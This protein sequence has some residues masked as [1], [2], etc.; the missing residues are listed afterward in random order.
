MLLKGKHVFIVEDDPQNRVV[1]QMALI[2][3]GA[4]VDFERWGKD[5]LK[6]LIGIGPVDVIILDLMLYNG[7]S[8]YDVF[9]EIREVEQ[10]KSVPIIAVS[11]IDPSVA[12]PE[13]RRRGFSGFIAKPI[14]IDM[15][16]AQIA[17]VLTGEKVW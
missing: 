12:L 5:T 14:D 1:F 2:L 11:A 8:G 4:R 10:F 3:H 7:V 9:D 13:T 15:F 16:P 17:K 6:I